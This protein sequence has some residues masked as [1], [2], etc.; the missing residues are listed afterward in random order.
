MVMKVYKIKLWDKEL[1]CPICNQRRFYLKRVKIV[2]NDKPIDNEIRYLFECEQCGYDMMFGAI[3]R[4]EPEEK[5][6]ISLEEI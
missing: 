3:T 4:W 6:N 2:D 5:L 1:I